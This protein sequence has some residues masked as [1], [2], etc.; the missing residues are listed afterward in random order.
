MALRA[1]IFD[2]D[3]II[4]D[5]ERVEFETLNVLYR[6][7]GVALTWE[8]WSICIGTAGAFDPYAHL[9]K[10]SGD[11][12]DRDA[13][14]GRR[15]ALGAERLARLDLMP[16]V[17]ERLAEAK[18]LDLRLAIASSSEAAWVEGHLAAR[19][20]RRWFDAVAVRNAIL[21]A[22]PKPDLYLAALAALG[23]GAGEAVAF[24]DSMNG[25]AAAKAAG[26]FTVAVPNE[27]TRRM[28]LSRADLR[29]GSLLE[30]SLAGLAERFGSNG[31]KG[32]SANS[33]PGPDRVRESKG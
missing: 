32:P 4:L 3:G 25:I 18:A 8:D 29:A 14:R 1:V 20:L 30:V 11:P 22:K 16:G 33:G 27:M 5:T 6:E 13:M 24:E 28:D 9:E 10:L 12:V 7:R 19:G 17:R 31:T 21:P 2:F 26:I 23:A 15:S